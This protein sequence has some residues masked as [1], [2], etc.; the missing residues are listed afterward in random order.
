MFTTIPT[1]LLDGMTV[2]GVVAIATAVLCPL[3]FWALTTPIGQKA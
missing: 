2:V 1:E 3:I